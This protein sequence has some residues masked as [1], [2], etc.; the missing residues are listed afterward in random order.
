MDPIKIGGMVAANAAPT[1]CR[2]RVLRD[3]EI[4]SFTRFS[5]NR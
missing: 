5:G 1:A 3:S 2:R 4:I